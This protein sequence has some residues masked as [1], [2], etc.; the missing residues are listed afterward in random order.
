M[1]KLSCNKIFSDS[2]EELVNLNYQ[3]EIKSE[4]IND[5]HTIDKFDYDNLIND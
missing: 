4:Y 5:K 1:R 3:L 2:K